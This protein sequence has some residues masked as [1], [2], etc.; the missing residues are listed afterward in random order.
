MTES[1]MK[2]LYPRECREMGLMYSGTMI[3]DFC[4]QFVSRNKTKS[5]VREVVEGK[6]NRIPRRF[7]EV[8]IMV[9]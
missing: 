6:V 4:Y 1:G 9:M 3:G 5:G 2:R 7:G 8:P